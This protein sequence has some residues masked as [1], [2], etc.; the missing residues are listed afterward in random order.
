MSFQRPPAF[1]ANGNLSHAVYCVESQIAF[2]RLVTYIKIH[3]IILLGDDRLL[4]YRQ[5]RIWRELIMD[6]FTETRIS[7]F[8]YVLQC[9]PNFEFIVADQLDAKRIKNYLPTMSR[10]VVNPRSH[11][12]KPYFPGYLFV[13]GKLDQLY[14]KRMGLMRGVVGLVSFGDAPASVA[15]EV[16]AAV[17]KQVNQLDLENEKTALDILAGERVWIDDPRLQGIEARF[18]R[19]LNGE[20]R[21]AVLLTLLEGR[22]IRLEVPA[23]KVKKRN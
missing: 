3:R 1:G 19:C 4:N 6:N 5:R 21:V 2:R 23:E 10:R 18:E 20:E 17:H 12:H 15:P 9:K 8:W 7:E 16:I 22:T 14:E 11:K 13:K